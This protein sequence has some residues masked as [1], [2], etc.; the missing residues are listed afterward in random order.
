MKTHTPIIG[1]LLATSL[2]LPLLSGCGA[3]GEDTGWV[4]LPGM[5]YSQ[6]IDPYDPDP[7]EKGAT[8]IWLAPEGTVAQEQGPLR[9]GKDKA[10][11]ARAG[12]TLHNPVKGTPEE[13]AR[14]QYIFE[15]YCGVCHGKEGKGDGTVVGAERFP[16]PPSLHAERART[17]PDGH[18]F[19]IISR[20]QVLMPAYA[21]QVRP[22]DRWK[23]IAWLRK[24]QAGG[25]K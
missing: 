9:Y 16:N 25:A 19:H 5:Y 15:T 3:G 14:G 7:L 21:A 2:A 23:A 20:G 22:A 10:E 17:L 24:L 8:S 18:I 12:R 13:L 6:A 4:P 11:A 1:A